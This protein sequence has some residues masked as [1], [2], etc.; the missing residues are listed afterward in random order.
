MALTEATKVG[1]HLATYAPQ[2][3]PRTVEDKLKDIASIVDYGAVSGQDCTEALQNACREACTV[4][5]PKGEFLVRDFILDNV[6]N[7]NI[8][9][10]GGIIVQ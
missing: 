9:G 8:I 6:N 7:I 3:V 5:I 10:M 4:I 2:G 1:S